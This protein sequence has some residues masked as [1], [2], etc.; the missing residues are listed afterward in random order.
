MNDPRYT[1]DTGREDEI[2]SNP[3]EMVNALQIQVMAIQ[4][5]L[6]SET[7]KQKDLINTIRQF[8]L[9]IFTKPTHTTLVQS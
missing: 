1:E 3:L 7:L 5:G 6:Y 8:H 2:G 4:Q 9:N